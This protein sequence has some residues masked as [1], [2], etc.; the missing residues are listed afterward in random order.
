MT[1]ICVDDEIILAQHTAALCRALPQIEITEAFVSGE[2]ALDWLKENNADIAL[3]DIDMPGMNGIELAKKIKELYQNTAIIFLTGYPQ[4]AV[5]AFQIR[6]SGYLLKPVSREDLSREVTYALSARRRVNTG[7]AV[8]QTFGSFEVYSHG[9][10]IRFRS[11]ES[12]E[13]LALLVDRR[14]A[15][16]TRSEAFGILREDLMYDRSRQKWF[17]KVIR[18]MRDTLAENGIEEIFELKQG[19]LRIRPEL[20]SCDLFRLF[21]GDPE[22]VR[23]F[24]GEYMKPYTWAVIPE[25]YIPGP[26]ET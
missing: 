16:L 23:S 20:I 11:Q 21:D 13:L 2:D 17:D 19:H 5:D 15:S 14:G 9:E 12:K 10:K 3:L 1:A 25:T 6:A 8:V 26:G 24:H 22:A 7:V 18:S 4:F